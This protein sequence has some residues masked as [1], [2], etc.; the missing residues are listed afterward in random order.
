MLALACQLCKVGCMHLVDVD[1]LRKIWRTIKS[2]CRMETDPQSPDYG[3]SGASLHPDWRNFQHFVGWAIVSGYAEGLEIDRV[4]PDGPYEPDN[5]RWL[6][7][8]AASA[9]PGGGNTSREYTDRELTPDSIAIAMAAKVP[10]K[11]PDGD[12]LYLQIRKNGSAT[13]HYKAPGS[14][15]KGGITLGSFP[16]LSLAE[17]RAERERIALASSSD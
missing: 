6:P 13:W 4:I 8:S 3:K 11:W 1:R 17:A 16:A 9:K 2:Q 12:G 15:G 10:A 5:C 14:L 7:P